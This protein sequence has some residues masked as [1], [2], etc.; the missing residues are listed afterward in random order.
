MIE[1]PFSGVSRKAAWPYHLICI[2]LNSCI[3]RGTERSCGRTKPS[4][5]PEVRPGT[6]MAP[7]ARTLHGL[8]FEDRVAVDAA[9]LD[10]F[11][12][13]PLEDAE[14]TR[15]DARRR[16]FHGAG[17]AVIVDL[18]PR[19]DRGKAVLVGVDDFTVAAGDVVH[20]LA[21]AFG[22]DL[23][24][25]FDGQRRGDQEIVVLDRVGVRDIAD[26]VDP[27]RV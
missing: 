8:E 13:L 23:A 4:R 26:V 25:L 1:G 6:P 12:V 2:V 18:V 9:H 7:R 22:V 16:V 19:A 14:E 15:D 5:R 11:A 17:H 10:E 3:A 24:G 20:R 27:L 21:P